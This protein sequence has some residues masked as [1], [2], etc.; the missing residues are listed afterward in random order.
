MTDLEPIVVR[1]CRTYDE[2][3]RA[4]DYLSDKYPQR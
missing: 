2:A 3:Q 4:V 1:E